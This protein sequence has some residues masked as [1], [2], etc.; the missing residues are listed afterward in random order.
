MKMKAI[1]PTYQGGTVIL[2]GEEFATNEQ[3]GRQLAARG[4]A[5]EQADEKAAAPKKA[6]TKKAV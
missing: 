1:R 5:A 3:H 2:A 4:Y 6:A